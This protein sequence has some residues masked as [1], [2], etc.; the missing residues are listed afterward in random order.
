M[1]EY[2]GE[3]ISSDQ[4]FIE[5]G[6]V[7]KVG[8]SRFRYR[9]VRFDLSTAQVDNDVIRL[10]TFKE[11]DR[12][13]GMTLTAAA[14]IT[15][16]LMNL[17]YWEHGLNHDGPAVDLNFHLANDDIAGMDAAEIFHQTNARNVDRAL[18][19]WELLDSRGLPNYNGIA[20]G[21][22]YDLV[23]EVAGTIIG[24]GLVVIG[25]GYISGD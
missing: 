23:L 19:L 6:Y 22:M 20:P 13:T 2:Y 8:A 5:L 24:S 11:T 21:I 15:A 17:G 9:S 16:A 18:P 4:D 25:V 3:L 14:G 1:A 10:M 7:P 12:I